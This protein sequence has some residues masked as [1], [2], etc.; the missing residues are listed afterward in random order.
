VCPLS[1]TGSEHEKHFRKTLSEKDLLFFEHEQGLIQVLMLFVKVMTKSC[2]KAQDN[3]SVISG[4]RLDH[5]LLFSKKEFDLDDMEKQDPVAMSALENTH[6]SLLFFFD[7][8]QFTLQ[9]MVMSD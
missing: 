4:E 8:Y 7:L 5:Y 3:Q 2:L 9:Y 6:Y 1:D